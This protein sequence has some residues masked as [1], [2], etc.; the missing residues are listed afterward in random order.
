MTT[1]A[2][3]TERRVTS[4][5]ADAGE[6]LCVACRWVPDACSCSTLLELR[7]TRALEAIADNLGLV[8]AWAQ[9]LELDT[10]EVR[11]I[12]EQL[13]ARFGHL[14]STELERRTRPIARM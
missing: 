12:L 6:L 8:A 10:S 2:L 7:Q 9:G 11:R 5:Q 4:G 13:G 14:E 3:E 1:P